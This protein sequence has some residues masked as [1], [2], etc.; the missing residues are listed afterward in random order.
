MF[1]CRAP[2]QAEIVERIAELVESK[3]LDGV[4]DVRDESDREGL[5]VVVE[6]RWGI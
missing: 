1:L 2:G 4:T 5:R 6:V 3:A